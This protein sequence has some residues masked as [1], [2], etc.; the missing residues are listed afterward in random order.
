MVAGGMFESVLAAER[1]MPYETRTPAAASRTPT[2]QI[3]LSKRDLSCARGLVAAAGVARIERY[4]AWLQAG[5][6]ALQQ[7]LIPV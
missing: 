5:L 6:Q 7:A 4:R 1:F 2:H 3:R